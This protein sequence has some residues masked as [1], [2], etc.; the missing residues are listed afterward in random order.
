MVAVLKPGPAVP[1][2]AHSLLGITLVHLAWAAQCYACPERGSLTILPTSALSLTFH[3]LKLLRFISLSQETFGSGSGIQV[4]GYKRK[5]RSATELCPNCSRR[6][7]YW[8]VQTGSLPADPEMENKRA[9]HWDRRD[10]KDL[11]KGEA[12]VI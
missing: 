6:V 5:G 4:M 10:E 11:T 8:C 1:S 3:L 12:S 2:L 9:M 7:I